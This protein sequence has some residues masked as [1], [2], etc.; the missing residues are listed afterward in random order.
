MVFFTGCG[1]AR[2]WFSRIICRIFLICFLVFFFNWLLHQSSGK[3]Y[4]I[5]L[6]HCWSSFFEE[7]WIFFCKFSVSAPADCYRFGFVNCFY[8]WLD[9]IRSQ[10]SLLM[11]NFVIL[12]WGTNFSLW[13]F[14]VFTKWWLLKGLSV[15]FQV[16]TGYT[17]G[18]QL[19]GRLSNLS[20]PM[21]L[22][23]CQPSNFLVDFC[24]KNFRHD[25]LY[26]HSTGFPIFDDN[27]WNLL[28]IILVYVV[29]RI[30][31]IRS[32]HLYRYFESSR[33]IL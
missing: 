24:W 12:V 15:T 17:E 32:L 8:A 20:C 6:Y 4:F 1:V 22:Y 30:G 26:C 27:Y 2:A 29:A 5:Y 18:M 23:V 14:T 10:F 21:F 3:C 16:R 19:W 11:L 31:L 9:V 33:W 7:I 13:M 25:I 28:S